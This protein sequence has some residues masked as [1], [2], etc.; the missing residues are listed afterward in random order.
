MN[1]TLYDVTAIMVLGFVGSGHCLGMCGP[2]VVALPGRTGTF[3]AHLFYHAGRL[4]TYGAIGALLG[5]IG[6]MSGGSAVMAATSKVQL[7]ITLAV[8]VALLLF[9][10]NRVRLLP[11]P[12]W[13]TGLDPQKIPG[14]KPI[15]GRALAQGDGI[16]IFLSGLFLGAL[17]CGLSFAAFARS[18]AAGDLLSG[19]VL[20]FAFGLGT[21]P[22]LLALGT[23]F[24]LFV[25]RYRTQTEIIAGL[26]L[27][28]MAIKMF[29]KIW[30]K[31]G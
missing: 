15:F 8:A 18:L 30:H 12:R 2:L 25:R 9:A 23:G 13:L 24:G 4:T 6:G 28:A 22:A 10:L 27:M 19:G 7:G 26:I 31:L 11:E 29:I 16:S 20:A 1:A 17:P 3:G 14:F 21:L 5:A